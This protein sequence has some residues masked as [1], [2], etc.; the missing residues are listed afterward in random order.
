MIMRDPG[1]KGGN[2]KAVIFCDNKL[3]FDA[4]FDGE[5]NGAIFIFLCCILWSKTNLKILPMDIFEAFGRYESH[6]RTD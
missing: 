1:E 4:K 3:S 2:F 6:F 5:F